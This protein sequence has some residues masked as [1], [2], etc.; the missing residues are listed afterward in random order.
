MS[1][2]FTDTMANMSWADLQQAVDDAALVLLPLGVMEE[3]GPHLCLGTDIYVA[4]RQCMAVQTLLAQRGYPSV[5]APPFYWGVCQ[6][7]AGF[8]GSFTMR[9][10]TVKAVLLDLLTSLSEFGFRRVYGINAHGDI[11]HNVAI[12]EAFRE[13]NAQ[14]PLRACYGFADWRLAPFGLTGEEPFLFIVPSSTLAFG[15]ADFPDVHGGDIE[16]ALIHHFYPELA[17]TELAKCLPPVSLPMGRDMDWLLGGRIKE[18][19]PQGYLGAPAQFDGV[20]VT[21][22]MEDAAQRICDGILFSL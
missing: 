9:K 22:Y 3:H 11:E 4:H 8:I 15:T 14:L 13:A 17:D 21:A 2:I 19:S 1:D 20:D 18:F 6:A 10:E 5:I 7:N 16:T 12:L